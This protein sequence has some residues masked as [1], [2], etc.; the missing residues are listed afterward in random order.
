MAVVC[1]LL[2]EGRGSPRPRGR[3]TCLAG[4]LCSLISSP[5]NNNLDN[6]PYPHTRRALLLLLLPAAPLRPQRSP[7]RRTASGTLRYLEPPGAGTL[8]RVT[9]AGTSL[10]S[11]DASEEC[12]LAPCLADRAEYIHHS[13][14][15][16][17]ESSLDHATP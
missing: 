1:T 12:V 13:A 11:S 3:T 6:N 9:T 15:E 5:L 16:R 2:A 14:L 17:L 4:K 10:I 8:H 7:S